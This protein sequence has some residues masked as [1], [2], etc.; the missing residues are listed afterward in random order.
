LESPIVDAPA[1]GPK[2][3]ARFDEIGC[4]WVGRFLD[5]NANEIVDELTNKQITFSL[6]RQWQYQAR[7]SRLT[8][9]GAGL[10]VNLGICSAEQLAKQHPDELHHQVLSIAKTSEG[11][12]LLR[13]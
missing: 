7:L 5:R 11:K 4:H 6:V 3:A 1:I 13:D 10:L 12:R 2:T 8:A 9:A